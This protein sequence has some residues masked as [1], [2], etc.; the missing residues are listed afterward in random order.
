MPYVGADG[1]GQA[2]KQCRKIRGLTPRLSFPIA[3]EFVETAQNR[4]A[5]AD[6]ERQAASLF[7]E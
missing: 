4:R 2:P 6:A 7:R 5:S 1:R 3:V